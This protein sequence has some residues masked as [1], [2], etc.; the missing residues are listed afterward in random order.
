MALTP[1]DL[2]D[3]RG[4]IRPDWF[5]DVAD[6]WDRLE[7]YLGQAYGRPEIANADDQ[8]A[9]AVRWV[10]YR[11]YSALASQASA[12]VGVESVTLADQGS[13]KM[14]AG[15]VQ[16]SEWS[17]RAADAL[18]SWRLLTAPP[19]IARSADGRYARLQWPPPV[20]PDDP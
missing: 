11:T 14:A 2:I 6:T 13:F 12:S 10:E 8:D 9:A 16:V 3:P 7:V 17:R 18:R 4:P 20:H 5:D 15:G 1:H 19:E